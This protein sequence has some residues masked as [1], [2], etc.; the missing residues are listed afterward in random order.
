MKKSLLALSTFALLASQASAV[1][2]HTALANNPK[3]FV[4]QSIVKV[5]LARLMGNGNAAYLQRNFNTVSTLQNT[6]S[7]VAVTGC[8]AHDC[9][10]FGS[11]VAFDKKHDAFKVWL[12]VNGKQRIF[13]ERG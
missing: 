12:V 6:G 11:M 2:V 5:R 10:S 13:Q 4:S 7:V 9:G 8:R 3:A 1:Q